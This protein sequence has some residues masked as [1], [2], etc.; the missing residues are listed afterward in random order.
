LL[1]SAAAVP[2]ATGERGGPLQVD[3]M[4]ERVCVAMHQLPVRAVAT[5]NVRDTERQVL[6]R[7]REGRRSR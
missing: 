7:S 6:V 1:T 4:Y 3:G 2:S 5:V